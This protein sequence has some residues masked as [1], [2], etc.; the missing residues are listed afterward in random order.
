MKKYLKQLL[1]YI[2]ATLLLISAIIGFSVM[3][4]EGQHVLYS[5]VSD[6]F[7]FLYLGISLLLQISLPIFTSI[8]AYRNKVN[9]WLNFIFVNVILWLFHHIATVP[10]WTNQ[11]SFQINFLSLTV[12]IFPVF[13]SPMLCISLLCAI[14]FTIIGIVKKCKKRR[15][16]L[17]KEQPNKA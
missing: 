9:T 14:I 13:L 10:L 17:T 15:A 6:V 8:F 11:G 4:V 5:D 12:Y 16:A 1:T 7:L 3:I 2:P